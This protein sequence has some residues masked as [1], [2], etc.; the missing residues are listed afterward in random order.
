[1]AVPLV[2]VLVPLGFLTL[3]VGA[4]VPPIARAAAV[5]LGWLTVLMLRVVHWFGQFSIGSYRI[6]GLPVWVVVTFLAAMVGVALALRLAR[7][8]SKRVG[9]VAVCTLAV[10]AI[11]VAT[12]PFAPQWSKGKLELTVLDVGQGD[13]LF[14]VSPGGR[15]LLI[16]GGGAFGGFPGTKSTAG[17]IQEKRPFLLVFGLAGFAKLTASR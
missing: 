7:P 2:G 5:P 8:G 16:D 11:V 3:I 17:S 12:Y 10:A 14:V 4:I 15:T 9:I 13:S 6:P 1:V